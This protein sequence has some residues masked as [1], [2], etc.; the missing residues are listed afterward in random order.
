MVPVLSIADGGLPEFSGTEAQANN[1]NQGLWIVKAVVSRE[2][3]IN[4]TGSYYT[5]DPSIEILSRVAQGWRNLY[6]ESRFAPYEVIN[7]NGV[8]F[9]KGRGPGTAMGVITVLSFSIGSTKTEIATV[10]GTYSVS[11]RPKPYE[12]LT[13]VA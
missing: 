4:Q 2:G 8:V 12:L 10:N 11:G 6:F 7:S 13:P 9:D 1:K 3:T 5:K